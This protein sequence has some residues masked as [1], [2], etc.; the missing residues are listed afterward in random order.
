MR[1][2]KLVGAVENRVYPMFR[3]V[4]SKITITDLNTS[5]MLRISATKATSTCIPI[6]QGLL[7]PCLFLNP[8][9]S[10]RGD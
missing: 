2:Y 4:L 10:G 5:L 3:G 8:D 7:S 1:H 9:L 6:Y